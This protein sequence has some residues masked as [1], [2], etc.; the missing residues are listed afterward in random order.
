VTD[1]VYVEMVLP[2]ETVEKIT[3]EVTKRVLAEIGVDRSAAE[4]SPYL[5]VL[6]AAALMRASRGR[7][8]DLLSQRR[9]TKYRDGTRVLLSRAEIERY[10][11]GEA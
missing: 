1:S 9:L 3:S 7:I 4:R 2:P 5:T 8:Y 6:E 10:L 11:A